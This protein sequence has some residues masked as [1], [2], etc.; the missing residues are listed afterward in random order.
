[1]FIHMEIQTASHTP[2]PCYVL[3]LNSFV[4][5]LPWQALNQCNNLSSLNQFT[6]ESLDVWQAADLQQKKSKLLF[7]RIDT[8]P[9]SNT[10]AAQYGFRLWKWWENP[11]LITIASIW[12]LFP[13]VNTIN[14]SM[15]QTRLC[16][17]LLREMKGD[18][19][20]VAFEPRWCRQL[21]RHQRTTLPL[22]TNKVS[23][24]SWVG[25][26]VF[27]LPVPSHAFHLFLWSA[28]DQF[29]TG[30]DQW[31]QFLSSPM[32]S[33]PAA[34]LS[35]SPRLCLLVAP[36][37]VKVQR[38]HCQLPAFKCHLIAPHTPPPLTSALTQSFSSLNMLMGPLHILSPFKWRPFC[39]PPPGHGYCSCGRCIC[40][41]GWFGKLCQ[42][43]RS[44]DIS[45]DQSKE[46]C[47]TSDGVM[48]S[49][50]GT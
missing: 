6:C 12:P 9:S 14:Q 28:G 24:V 43:S 36:I 50:K 45:D 41:D 30:H 42:F 1:M 15:M 20:G 3:L 21:L 27:C 31:W 32:F 37:S 47:E 34:S 25:V 5:L 22:L 23:L 18:R 39:P 13:D 26:F 46:L 33:E 38:L 17:R 11:L 40:K 4:E 44:C 16:T 2:A 10:P 29:R 7:E 48:C 35:S 19:S 8:P 49:G